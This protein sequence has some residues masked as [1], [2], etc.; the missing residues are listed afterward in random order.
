MSIASL[1]RYLAA[2]SPL[3]AAELARQT[4]PVHDDLTLDALPVLFPAI[5]GVFGRGVDDEFVETLLTAVVDPVTASG[6][7]PAAW[8]K[9]RAV[10]PADVLAGAVADA[11]AAPALATMAL[12][13]LGLY[14]AGAGADDAVAAAVVGPAATKA[15]PT[16]VVAQAERTVARLAGGPLRP[17]VVQAL[18]AAK[19][20]AADWIVLARVQALA[21]VLLERSYADVPAALLQYDVAGAAAEDELAAMVCVEFYERV[22]ELNLAP[23]ALAAVE[24]QVRAIVGLHARGAHGVLGLA[25]ARFVGALAQARPELF[26]ALD[27]D[28][29]VVRRLSARDERDAAVLA[30][31]PAPYLAAHNPELLRTLPV[32][33]ATLGV[34]ANVIATDDA[35]GSA[36][37]T[38]AG[39]RPDALMRL[40]VPDLLRLAWA[41]AG[42]AWGAARLASWP[43]VMGAVLEGRRGYDLATLRGDVLARLAAHAAELGPW[44]ATVEAEHRAGAWGV[45]GAGPAVAVEDRHM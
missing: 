31:L 43:A 7:G 24:P 15:T 39:L 19:A 3:S 44:R 27:A 25:A 41:L 45:A 13:L 16:T 37:A 22:L 1:A 12:K 2:G 4:V 9:V 38:V 30:R 23:A 18:A 40:P 28:F 5:V 20:A 10:V 21:T 26:A 17:A 35:A 33:A 42:P 14:A 34:L 32:A 11:A 29:G 8:D 36:T 6:A